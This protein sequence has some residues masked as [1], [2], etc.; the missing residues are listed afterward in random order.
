MI[1][2]LPLFIGYIIDTSEGS[3]HIPFSQLFLVLSGILILSNTYVFIINKDFDCVLEHGR[4][5]A[6][7]KIK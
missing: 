5:D 3:W 7:D 2:L 1:S 4:N 6:E